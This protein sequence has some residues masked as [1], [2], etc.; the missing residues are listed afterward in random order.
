MKSNFNEK[1][2]IEKSSKFAIKFAN[3]VFFLGI[4]FLI[5]VAIYCVYLINNRDSHSFIFYFSILLFA[6][7]SSFFL[8]FGLWNFREELKVNL[9]ILFVT[10]I[11]SLYSIEAYFE[12]NRNHEQKREYMGDIYDDRT[13][14]EVLEDFKKKSV[15]AHPVIFPHLF[16][17][18][19][20]LSTPNGKL[21]PLGGIS[22]TKYVY[23][24]EGGYWSIFDSDE[25]GFNNP[26]GL[27][28]NK[29]DIAIIGDSFSEG[30]CVKPDKTVAAVLR[31]TGL[32]LISF[33][34]GGNGSLIE[35][36][37][38][39]EY[40]EPLRPSIVLWIYFSND[41]HELQNELNSQILKKYLDESDFSQNL[42]DR[43]DEIDIAL[44]DFIKNEFYRLSTF[45]AD[46]NNEIIKKGFTIERIIG[47]AKLINI[48]TRLNIFPQPSKIFGEIL[49]SAKK[50][51]SDWGGKL[52][53]VY[54]PPWN[55]ENVLSVVRNLG[56]PIINIQKEVFDVHRDPISLFPYEGSIHYNDEGYRLIAE[57]IYNRL[58]AD[59]V[60]QDD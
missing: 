43:Q 52:Y 54:L 40:A 41:L 56:I 50:E 30:A 16:I 36:A 10:T 15:E 39:N 32:N 29:I 2:K 1:N 14:V 19:D 55:P 3:K 6:L 25:Y 51:V 21:F 7:I 28:K 49:Y 24:N 35:L 53:F 11:I 38:L 17:D 59:E 18:S 57:A 27:Y 33:G 20:G 23:C 58:N 5:F 9:S 60:L 37:T 48:R 4:L 31:R 42:I 8:A 46:D 12:I 45:F 44:A 22:N 47:N 26:L 34:K 13:K